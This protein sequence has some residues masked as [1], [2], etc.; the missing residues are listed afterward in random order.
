MDYI[1]KVFRN[2][3]LLSIFCIVIGAALIVDP[4]FFTNTVGRVIGGLFAAY[5]AVDLIRYFASEDRYATGLVKGIL[6]CSAGVFILIQ[7]DFIPKVLAVICGIYM[8]ISGAVNLQDSLNLKKVGVPN[9]K[10]SFV[11]AAVTTA[12]GVVL[13]VDPMFSVDVALT[14]LGVALLISGISNI[15]GCASAASKLR[16][17]D[18]AARKA[19]K[20]TATEK[21]RLTGKRNR[22]DGGEEEFI[23]I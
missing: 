16:K 18:K 12:V 22:K 17:Y 21:G 19:A 4:G 10:S 3:W 7:P 15:F 2:Y 8:T 5:G 20:H 14:I 6:M 1:K 11:P 13:I 9:W 23:D